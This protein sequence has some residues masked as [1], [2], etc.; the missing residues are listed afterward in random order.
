MAC[1]PLKHRRIVLFAFGM[2]VGSNVAFYSFITYMQKYL[3]ASVGFPIG[4]AAAICTVGL[5]VLAAAQLAAGWV[6]D[7]IGRKPVLLWLGV[8]GAL[9]TVPLMRVSRSHQPSSM[10]E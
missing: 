3:V 8:A 1:R 5:L 4:Q 6:S 9:F 7:V 2:S 10:R